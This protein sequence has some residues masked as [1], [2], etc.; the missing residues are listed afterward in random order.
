[1]AKVPVGCKLPSGLIMELIDPAPQK[2]GT[3]PAPPGSRVSL[4]GANRVASGI[5]NPAVPQFGLTYVDEEFATEWF[6]RN[7][8]KAFVQSGAVFLAKDEKV[9]AGEVKD[10]QLIHTGLEPLVPVV[11]DKGGEDRPGIVVADKKAYDKAVAQSQA[12]AQM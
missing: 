4:N 10:R 7:R 9:F 12:G 5:I 11:D 3:M 8:D 1:M 2:N 6:K